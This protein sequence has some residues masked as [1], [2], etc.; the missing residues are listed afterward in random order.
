MFQSNLVYT[1][2]K[3]CQNGRNKTWEPSELR[4]ILTC[5][6]LA[7][8][9]LCF[10]K[11]LQGQIRGLS[12]HEQST[13]LLL[14]FSTHL[15]LQTLR[16]SELKSSTSAQGKTDFWVLQALLWLCCPLAPE[17]L[18]ISPSLPPV[19]YR[20]HWLPLKTIY[21]LAGILFIAL[22]FFS[23]PPWN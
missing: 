22:F 12:S 15:H 16:A 20:C 8:N 18:P 23:S 10:R 14:C 13:N 4:A 11:L 19:V 7:S 17:Q 3:M 21:F 5:N 2:N 9:N 1:E 6:L